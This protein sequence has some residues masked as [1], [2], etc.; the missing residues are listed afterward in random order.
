MTN[1]LYYYILL[2]ISHSSSINIIF[3]TLQ[4]A[5]FIGFTVGKTLKKRCPKMVTDPRRSL[6]TNPMNLRILLQSTT[7]SDYH[8]LPVDLH[9]SS[10]G[11]HTPTCRPLVVDLFNFCRCLYHVNHLDLRL[12]LYPV[13]PPRP[14]TCC[15]FL[16]LHFT[17]SNHLDLR[18]RLSVDPP[19]LDFHCK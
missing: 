4:H 19:R 3:T 5:F 1:N 16:R 7:K 13:E 8:R 14:S 17:W 18:L 6:A 11:F 2:V 12:R 10:V 15:R 9:S